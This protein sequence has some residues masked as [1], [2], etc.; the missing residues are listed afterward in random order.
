MLTER[1]RAPMCTRPLWQETNQ[2]ARYGL[3]QIRGEGIWQR[4]K[5]ESAVAE[6][7]WDRKTQNRTRTRTQHWL[8]LRELE[9]DKEAL[10]GVM[11]SWSECIFCLGLLLNSFICFPFHWEILAF[12]THL[13]VSCPCQFR[14][15]KCNSSMKGW[16]A[17]VEQRVT[18]SSQAKSWLGRVGWAEHHPISQLCARQCLQLWTHEHRNCGLHFHGVLTLQGVLS[19]AGE[20]KEGYKN[21]DH[22]SHCIG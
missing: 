6:T 20:A 18:S 19:Q 2:S 7:S 22:N 4:K 9:A 14:S 17:R 16:G 8:W 15:G 11:C 3:G 10:L 21:T 13:R 5:E 12:S 1:L